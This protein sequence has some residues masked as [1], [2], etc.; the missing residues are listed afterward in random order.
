MQK[1]KYLLI[2][3]KQLVFLEKV[4]S[5]PSIHPLATLVF[6]AI[7]GML[8]QSSSYPL[9]IVRRRMQT[10]V[11]NQYTGILSTLKKIYV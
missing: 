3:L 8:G 11:K 10:D 1:S 5:N 7:A 4:N 9:D 2:G 6:G